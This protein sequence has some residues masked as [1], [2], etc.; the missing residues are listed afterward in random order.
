[1]RELIK[2]RKLWKFFII[3]FLIS[4]LI[5]NW[6]DISWV[7]NYKAVSGKIASFFKKEEVIKKSGGEEEPNVVDYSDK[8]NLIEV[9]AIGIQ[10]PIIFLEN[11]CAKD[12]CEKE[13]EQALKKGVLHYPNTA[14]PGE[15]GE[16]VILGHSAPENWP[17]IDYD[18]IFSDLDKLNP[19]DKIYVYFEGRRYVFETKEKLFLAAGQDLPQ[20][21]T[22]SDSMLILMS[23]WPPG[24]DRERIAVKA[25]LL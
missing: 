2:E 4:F 20:S 5:I 15:K 17:K 14:L 19:G 18:W 1:M 8:G 23:C 22:E 9:P 6:S 24:K 10:A 25:I 7:F 21:L 13:F 3:L 12:N 16:I 11:S